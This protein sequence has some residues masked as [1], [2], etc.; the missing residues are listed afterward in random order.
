MTPGFTTTSRTK[1]LIVA[2]LDE[3]FRDRSVTV[4]SKRLINE[5]F[6][7]IYEGTRV[8]AA[9]GYNDDLVMSLAI[10]L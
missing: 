10:G 2:K 7:F 1:P 6:V 9:S 5:L 3:Y 8:G 4:H